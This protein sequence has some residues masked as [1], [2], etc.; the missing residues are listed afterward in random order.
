MPFIPEGHTAYTSLNAHTSFPNSEL[1]L[2]IP[3]KV[4]GVYELCLKYFIIPSSNLTSTI[5]DQ[6]S[7]N[8]YTARPPLILEGDAELMEDIHEPLPFQSCYI[9]LKVHGRAPSTSAPYQIPHLKVVFQFSLYCPLI[10]IDNSIPL[11][12]SLHVGA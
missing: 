3:T 10:Y 6:F 8:R 12:N 7:A 11:N 9:E 5:L 4:T 1:I 2:C